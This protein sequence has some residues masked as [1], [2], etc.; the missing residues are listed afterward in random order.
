MSRSPCPESS[1]HPWPSSSPSSSPQT[2]HCMRSYQLRI[3]KRRIQSPW[4]VQYALPLRQQYRNTLLITRAFQLGIRLSYCWYH[5]QD[6]LCLDRLY[7]VPRSLTCNCLRCRASHSSCRQPF[8][9][10]AIPW[11]Q[12]N[13]ATAETEGLIWRAWQT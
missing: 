11:A 8:L 6:L 9:C 7:F 5:R 3:R 10:S 4:S 1:T 13:A 12:R 2:L